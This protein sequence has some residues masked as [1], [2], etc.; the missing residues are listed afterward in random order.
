MLIRA[1]SHLHNLWRIK[2]D[3][4]GYARSI[5]VT[6]GE[7]CRL[8]NLQIGT[9]GSEPYLV[10]IGEHVTVT[11]NVKFITHDGGVWIFRDKSPDLDVF[12]S[13]V[14]GNNVF[15]GINAIIL[16]G[17]TIGDNCVI[18][19]GSLVTRDIPA[20]TVA[21]GIPARCIKGIEVYGESVMEK[22]SFVRSCSPKRK[23]EILTKHFFKVD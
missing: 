10:K 19:A 8:I 15:I 5:G 4:V 16:P 17:V 1:C 18:G 22:A 20:G 12:G 13:I 9:F 21:A 6:V 14:V 23:R 3:P 7:R 11:D 2:K